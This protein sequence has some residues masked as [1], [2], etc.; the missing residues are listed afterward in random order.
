MAKANGNLY[1]QF[2]SSSH[3]QADVLGRGEPEAGGDSLPRELRWCLLAEAYSGG[4]LLDKSLLRYRASLSRIHQVARRG[5]CPVC[6][7]WGELL[8][9]PRL[10]PGLGGQATFSWRCQ[11]CHRDKVR[12][13]C[14]P[15][16]GG[17]HLEFEVHVQC[18]LADGTAEVR[19]YL[20]GP[21]ALQCL[22]LSVEQE[23]QLQ[24]MTLR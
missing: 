3:I 16:A 13:A 5:R 1:C 9:S 2:T 20:E 21:L 4:G 23:R 19:A 14:C 17:D 6:R 15:T 10:S 8:L 24:A 11:L 22:C 12:G 7:P 18:T